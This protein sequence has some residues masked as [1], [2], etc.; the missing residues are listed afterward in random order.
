MRKGNDKDN[1]CEMMAFDKRLKKNV[2]LINDEYIEAIGSV[3]LVQYNLERENYSDKELYF[4]AIAQDIV[5]QLESRGLS[6]DGLKLLSKKK[7][8]EN[9]DTLYYGMDYE[10]FLILRLAND[11]KRIEKLEA[12]VK[13]LTQLLMKER[14]E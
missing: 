5:N 6:D 2:N 9:D 3:D 7:V 13:L 8:S 4:G 10:Q 12:Q 14:N 11:E 1:V